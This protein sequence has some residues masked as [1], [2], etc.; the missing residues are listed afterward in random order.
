MTAAVASGNIALPTLVASSTPQLHSVDADPHALQVAREGMRQGVT[1][2]IATAVNLPFVA[3]AAKTGTA[4]V[5]VR[6]EYQN[7]WM[8]GFWPYDNPH[9]AYA[10]VLERMPA[11]TQVGGSIV[12]NDFFNW[13]NTNAP[14]YLR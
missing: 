12:M 11:G 13:L 4:Q 2:G 3:V 9:W 7:A 6:N 1:E 10:V 8:I 14:E 5:G